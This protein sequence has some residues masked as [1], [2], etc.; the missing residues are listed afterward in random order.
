MND[1]PVNELLS[2]E[3]SDTR[4]NYFPGISVPPLCA[5]RGL[6]QPETTSGRKQH[7]PP[8]AVGRCS[9]W[10]VYR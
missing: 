4:S 6:I 7:E 9:D 10:G 5:A 1:G 3:L 2:T 8:G